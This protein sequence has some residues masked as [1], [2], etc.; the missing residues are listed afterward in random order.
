MAN[1]YRLMTIQNGFVMDVA[2]A[3]AR[4]GTGVIAYP[5]WSPPRNNQLWTFEAEFGDAYH[6][7]SELPNSDLI[8]QGAED[9][10]TTL[11]VSTPNSPVSPNQLWKFDPFFP[12]FPAPGF[13]R[14]VLN[15]NLVVTVGRSATPGSLAVWPQEHPTGANQLWLLLPE[16]NTYDP[17]I[18]PI[19][20]TRGG[21]TIIGT[22]FQAGTPVI[23]VY[24][25]IDINTGLA[26]NGSF[27]AITDFGGAFVSGGPITNLHGTNSATLQITINLSVPEFPT[28]IEATWNGSTFTITH[29]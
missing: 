21:F 2:G 5:P 8:L 13:I 12:G 1:R 6:I 19:V 3:I 10:G 22:G 17:H 25:F 16:G 23:A 27:I 7:R 9:Q 14:S 24:E 4:P 11:E 28:Y 15:P 18:S 20:P 29:Q 26:E